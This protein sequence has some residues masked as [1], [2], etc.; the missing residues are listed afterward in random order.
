MREA[1]REYSNTVSKQQLWGKLRVDRKGWVYKI[2]QKWSK[3]N[4][5]FELKLPPTLW[6]GL[7]QNNKL[8]I[9]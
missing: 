2:Q 5:R 3:L 8:G 7:A 9:M 6:W 4:S 1:V